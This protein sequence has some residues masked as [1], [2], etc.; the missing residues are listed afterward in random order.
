MI[1][2]EKFLK[3]FETFL[4]IP[5]L[6]GCSGTALLHPA[7][8]PSRPMQKDLMEMT[9]QFPNLKTD[10]NEQWKVHTK[11]DPR[12]SYSVE[13]PSTWLVEE[14]GTSSFFL[15]PAAKSAR[16]S[17]SAVIINYKE[18]PPLPVQYAYK[19]LRKI[20]LDGEEIIVRKREP[21]AITEL[22]MAEVRRGDYTIEFK[23]FLNGNH[24]EIFDH[25]ISSFKFI[26]K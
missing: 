5:I 20:Q 13:Y 16:G 21:S 23:S 9:D 6:V 18:T 24:D 14:S 7:I 1:A 15:P 25:M 11:T 2:L 26:K 19:T 3:L 22:Y 10:K 8:E 4:T 17:I 12:F